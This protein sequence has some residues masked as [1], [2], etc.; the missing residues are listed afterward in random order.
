MGV[1]G[2][3]KGKQKGEFIRF[4]T[5]LNTCTITDHTFWFILKKNTVEIGS[6]VSESKPLSNC[7]DVRH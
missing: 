5:D 6:E 1:F 7:A 3:K 4:K 2:N